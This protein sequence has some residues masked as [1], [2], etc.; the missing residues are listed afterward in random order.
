MLCLCGGDSGSDPGCRPTPLISHAAWV[1]YIQHRGRLAGLSSGLIFLKQNKQTNKKHSRTIH[2]SVQASSGHLIAQVGQSTLPKAETG[3]KDQVRWAGH[4]GD[5]VENSHGPD[6][7]PPRPPSYKIFFLHPSALWGR[8]Q[9][10]RQSLRVK[11]KFERLRNYEKN[12]RLRFRTDPC[13]CLRGSRSWYLLSKPENKTSYYRACAPLLGPGQQ[14]P[15]SF[16][17]TPSHLAEHRGTKRKGPLLWR[18]RSKVVRPLRAAVGVWWP[19]RQ[20]PHDASSRWLAPWR[21]P[22]R[23]KASGSGRRISCAHACACVRARA[24]A[25]TTQTTPGSCWEQWWG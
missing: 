19:G 23:C 5:G 7:P 8:R 9:E 10:R 13:T 14:S 6:A 17:P 1:T 22:G 12:I 2:T 11:G 20:T 4:Q 16:Q 18:Q 3:A 21:A 24:W 25:T 15:G